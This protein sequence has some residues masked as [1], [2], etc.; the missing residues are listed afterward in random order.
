[1]S[2]PNPKSPL[3]VLS[4]FT[5]FIVLAL[6]SVCT[7]SAQ[8]RPN[9]KD[10]LR[11]MT[12]EEKVAQLSQLPGFPIPE[13][14]RQ[15]GIPEDVIRKYG[16]GSVLW[17]SDPK[18]INRIQH[19]AVDESRLHIPIL[20]GLDVIHGYHAIFPAPIAMASSWDPKLV[21]S[22]QTIAAR[23]AR[24]GG[25]AWTFA[26]MLDIARDARWGRMV[27]GA[28]EDPYLGA[29]IARAQV[30]GF[31]G[32]QPG[33]LDHV[34]A[35]AKH[36]AGYGAAD[37]GRDYDSSYIPEEQMWNTYLVPFKAAADAGVGSFMSAYMDLND[38][39][40]SGN[41]WLLH[42]V[43]RDTWSYKG[44]VVSDANAVH[45]LIIHGYARDGQDA[46]TKAF[47][48]GLNMDMAS[49]TYLKYL[50]AEVKA[51][52]VSMQ[53]IDDAVLPIL[54][55]KIRLGLFEHPYVDESKI[56]QVL[57]APEHLEL[58]RTAVQR[59]VVLLR[60]E[61]GALPLD[62]SRIKS[63][64]VIG[65]LADAEGDLLGMW[66]ALTKPGPTVSV[67]Q[68]IKNKVGDAVHVEFAH[69]PNIRRD[70][71]SFFEN[72]PFITIKEQPAQSADEKQK[73]MDEAVAVAKRSDVAVLVLGEIALMSG[74]AA[75]RSSL[76][77]S[78]GQEELLEAV[79]AT[80]KPV[81]L[82]LVNGRPLDISWAAE[83]VPAIL[84][85]W[86]SGSQAGNGIADILFGDANPGGHLP[87]SWPHNSGELPLYYNHTLTQAPEDA[88][89]FT[90][91]YWDALSTPLYPFGY[92]L[93]YT[94]FSF[95]N[96]QVSSKEAKVGASLDVSVDVTNTGS[97]AGD[98]VAQLYI[99]QRAGS[100]SRPVR[101][102]KGF[103][104]VNLQAGAKQTIHFKLGPDEL[105][106][107][108]PALKKWVVEP[109]QF[110]IWVGDNAQAKPH[111]EFALTK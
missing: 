111:A 78:G 43:L 41:R 11:Q 108:S 73:A 69:G 81:V 32:T 102:L 97:R 9:A 105:Q 2:E 98:T 31:Q 13:F 55:A 58:A 23:E 104:R 101:Q 27:E 62:K 99:H 76:K 4:R 29:A 24:A 87:V 21:E 20:F 79:A 42:D 61:Q 83:H 90:S 19:I 96:M 82:V 50:A 80:G 54:E 91:R 12:L 77:L 75:S 8:S 35:C 14:I 37:G 3:F 10:L 52:R 30:L 44:F 15:A 66:G 70:I 48:A 53:Q 103:Q 34:M 89:G 1:M 71:P 88:P 49:G 74:E 6:C 95:D 16:A 38:V 67:L 57:N 56:Q 100:A 51:G 106:F 60:N 68:G 22:A 59:S 17:V 45:S 18:Q 85:T 33:A 5:V 93:S 65:P 86:Y 109:E 110:D 47:S 72:I 94:T 7:L 64:A 84:E 63:I 28:G 46:A 25:I 26:P 39:P 36:F 40:A 92:G 107:W